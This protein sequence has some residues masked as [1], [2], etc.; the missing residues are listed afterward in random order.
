MSRPDNG[1]PAFPVHG[2]AASNGHTP[3]CDVWSD[4][5]GGASMRD[6]FAYGAMN[7][8][9]DGEGVVSGYEDSFARQCYQMADAMLKES[10]RETP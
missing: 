8:M 9:L 5:F 6:W 2:Y 7:A 10:N 3:P 1:G 4:G